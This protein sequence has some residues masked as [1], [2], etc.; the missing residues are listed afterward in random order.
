MCMW[1]PQ[2]YS[3]NMP[4]NTLVNS[5]LLI[6]NLEALLEPYLDNDG[7]KLQELRHVYI[8]EYGYNPWPPNY[9]P[10]IFKII[11]RK[12]LKTLAIKEGKLILSKEKLFEFSNIPS[13]S[14][15]GV[16]LYKNLDLA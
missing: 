9:E 8:R 3:K 4:L 6:E 16:K 2:L 10:K 15:E 7:L 14:H 11:V 12:S 1:P 13:Q 5:G